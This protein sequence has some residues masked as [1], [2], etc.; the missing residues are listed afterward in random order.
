MLPQRIH[1]AR[2]EVRCGR[3]PHTIHLYPNLTAADGEP[4]AQLNVKGNMDM[5]FIEKTVGKTP[6]IELQGK[7]M[8]G[9][10]S[11]AMQVRLKELIAA[12]Y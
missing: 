5:S 1:S 2:R 12:G 11:L 9:V 10:N 6:V 4:T 3:C 7:V 8:G